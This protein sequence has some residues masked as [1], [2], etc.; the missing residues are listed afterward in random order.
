MT[1]FKY[2]RAQCRSAKAFGCHIFYKNHV[3]ETIDND[4]P[5]LLSITEDDVFYFDGL[6]QFDD[7]EL[8]H[9]HYR[10]AYTIIHTKSRSQPGGFYSR[11]NEHPFLA[12]S[13]SPIYCLPGMVYHLPGMGVDL[14]V[15]ESLIPT[16]YDVYA[17]Y[18]KHDYLKENWDETLKNWRAWGYKYP[19]IGPFY[20]Y[21][22][23][24]LLPDNFRWVNPHTHKIERDEDDIFFPPREH[25]DIWNSW[26]HYKIGH[27]YPQLRE[28]Y[29]DDHTALPRGL[30]NFAV[31]DGKL[32]FCVTLDK[33]I[34]G[35]EDEIKRAYNL[36]AYD[37]EFFYDTMNYI[38]RNCR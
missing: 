3:L 22:G 20:Y 16:L 18:N 29:G 21:K 27:D 6:C 34:A 33:C 2:F 13:S 35:Q 14:D 31:K 8:S 10:Y 17:Q 5:K 19:K 11:D 28:E 12:F 30:V 36:G 23:S 4:L 7:D 15:V 9:L 26:N 25:R 38:C 37:V 24:L 1:K 32:S